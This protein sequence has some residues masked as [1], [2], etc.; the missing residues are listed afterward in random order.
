M[1]DNKNR[2]PKEIPEFENEDDEREFWATHDSCDY[3][4]WS[5]AKVA[6]F[7]NL[8]RTANLTDP[9]DLQ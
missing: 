2:G 7:P 8:K 6:T 1:N 5:R 9:T 4:D 3:F